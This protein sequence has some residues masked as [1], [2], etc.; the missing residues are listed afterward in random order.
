MAKSRRPP[1]YPAMKKAADAVGG[2]AALAERIGRTQGAIWQMT[3]RRPVPA[4]VAVEIEKIT[5]VPKHEL[6]PDLFDAP[7]R[8]RA[9]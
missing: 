5:G 7:K 9:A 3:H 6:R 1:K 2:Q 4:E 8:A